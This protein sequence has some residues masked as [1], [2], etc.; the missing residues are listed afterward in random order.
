[1]AVCVSLEALVANHEFLESLI[2]SHR[3]SNLGGGRRDRR[4][5]DG[6]FEGSTT[7]NCGDDDSKRQSSCAH[8]KSS[9]SSGAQSLSLIFAGGS[10][11]PRGRAGALTAAQ[12][13]ATK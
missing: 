5:L 13:L 3:C 6:K 9:L 12:R 10:F 11:S 1:M 8:G 7:K 2:R 4:E